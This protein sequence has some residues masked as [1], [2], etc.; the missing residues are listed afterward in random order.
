[1]TTREDLVRDAVI[2]EMVAERIVD[3]EDGVLVY[4]SMRPTAGRFM[5]EVKVHDI[6]EEPAES[7]PV[8]QT[9]PARQ[10]YPASAEPDDDA[11]EPMDDTNDTRS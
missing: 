2:G 8:L 3:T 10:F 6:T 1:M 11:V 4:P 5:V 9:T 7:G